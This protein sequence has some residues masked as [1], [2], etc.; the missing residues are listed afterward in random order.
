MIKVNETFFVPLANHIDFHSHKG[1]PVIKNVGIERS[2][3]NKK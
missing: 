3:S 2:E 1:H